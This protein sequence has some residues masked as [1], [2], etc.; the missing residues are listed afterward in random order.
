M[1]PPESPPPLVDMAALKAELERRREEL[2]PLWKEALVASSGSITE[3]GQSF[4]PALAPLQARWLCARLGLI[5]F[6]RELRWESGDYRGRPPEG[7]KPP[8]K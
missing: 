8:K 5:E 2:F 6:A 3:A 4:T 1:K 7:V